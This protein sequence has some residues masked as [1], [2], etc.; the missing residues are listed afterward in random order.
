M[1][2]SMKYIFILTMGVILL[3]S[4]ESFLDRQPLDQI[5]TGNFYQTASDAD[6]AVIAAYSAIQSINWHGKS[7]MIL[8]IPTDNTTT[9]GNDPDFSPIDNFTISSDNVPNAEFWTEHYRLVTLSNQVLDNVPGIDMDVDL[10]NSYLAEARFLRAY[11]YFDLVRIYG[12]VPIIKNV[13]NIDSDLY[14]AKSEVDEVY[15]FIIED[16][17]FAIEHLPEE[18][19]SSSFGRATMDAAKA[20][21][22][23][24][25]LTTKDFDLCQELCRE[26]IADGRYQLEED[27]SGNWLR[28]KSDNNSES[29]FQIQYVGCGPGNTG[30][31]LQAFFAPWGQGITQNSDGW[32]S[33]I[34]TAPNIDNPG[35]T[36]KDAYEPEDKRFYHTI[37]AAG[38]E[39]PMLNP[40]LGGYT[41]PA[42]GASRANINIKKYVIGG[43]PDV[44]FMSTPQNFHAI[45]YADVL[46]T[47]AEAACSRNGGISATPDVLEG[48]NA[49]RERAGLPSLDI[50]NLDQ[51]FLERRLEFAFENQ[52]WFDLLRTGKIRE[53][54]Q[55]H[56]KQM[57]DFHL[58][59]PIPSQEL[60]INTN[61]IQNPGY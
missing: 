36:I 20:T 53:T 6:L 41:Y 17:K 7:W 49:I 16:L 46:L 14:I 42:T 38:A 13:P 54:M 37:M 27:F 55:L 19:A 40:E 1:M 35:T 50:I 5:T 32:G 43:G 4:C 2:N 23:K 24:V 9:G 60:A 45:R 28:D 21:L 12:G 47:L 25:Y 52:R 22:A 57:Q 15:A 26:I 30:N 18:R 33:Q 39:Y 34:P 11:S 48:F 29:I 31:A 56:G 59:F 51:V 58:L 3:T 8:E 61:L 10:R 44:C